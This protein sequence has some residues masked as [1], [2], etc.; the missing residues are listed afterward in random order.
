MEEIDFR[1]YTETE[2][3]EIAKRHLLP[4]AMEQTG[5]SPGQLELSEEILRTVIEDYTMEAGVR[6][7][8]KQLDAVCRTAAVRLV[9]GEA[10]PIRVQEDELSTLFDMQP[11][12]HEQ[13]VTP[14]R[15]GIVTGLA[16]SPGGRRYSLYRN[17]V[18]E[19]KRRACPHRA[20]GRCDEGIRSDSGESCE[21]SVPG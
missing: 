8:R 14:D 7:L 2:K 18:Y 5:I 12:F 4:K 9:K 6:G 15:P 19:R 16:W 21:V 13:L 3:L 10:A 20:A 17:H 1:G 11:V